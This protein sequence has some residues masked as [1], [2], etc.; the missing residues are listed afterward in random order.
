MNNRKVRRKSYTEILQEFLFVTGRF[1]QST[2]NGHIQTSMHPG[3]VKYCVIS[4]LIAY[5]DKSLK[6]CKEDGGGGGGD[7]V[8]LTRCRRSTN[9]SEAIASADVGHTGNTNYP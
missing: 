4:I 2:K 1:P 5:L 7:C 6:A 9:I 3:Y 8:R